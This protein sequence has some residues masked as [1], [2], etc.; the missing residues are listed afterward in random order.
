[1][2][3]PCHKC[4]HTIE[5]GKAFCSQCGSPCRSPRSSRRCLPV[6]GARSR[7]R[8]HRRSDQSFASR[9][10]LC[11]STVRPGSFSGRC[12]DVP[13]PKSVCRCAWYG[14]SG[15]HVLSTPQSRNRDSARPGSQARRLQRPPAFRRLHHS[16]DLGRGGPSQRPRNT[17]RD[18]G[19]SPAGSRALSRPSGRTLPGICKI[20]RRFRV[21]DGSFFGFRISGLPDSRRSWRS[22]QCGV[23]GKA[24]SALTA[25]LA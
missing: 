19:Q 15:R 5:D 9:L 6:T 4:G 1:M 2:D 22:G 12:T 13:G 21:H 25:D 11:S 18:D 24:E 10:V 14:I 20:S 8:F 7:A 23:C 16:R 17:S 3:H